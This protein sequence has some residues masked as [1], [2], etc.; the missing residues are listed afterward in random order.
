MVPIFPPL[1]LFSGPSTRRT[2]DSL[3][4]WTSLVPFQRTGS[5]AFVLP[6]SFCNKTSPRNTR[7]SSLLGKVTTAVL[8]LLIER[9]KGSGG[10]PRGRKKKKKKESLLD[11]E[12]IAQ[13]K[14][15]QECGLSAG[16][17]VV[18]SLS[19]CVPQGMTQE[20][21]E[22]TLGSRKRRR[23]FSVEWFGS[24]PA[25]TGSTHSHTHSA[26]IRVRNLVC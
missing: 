20:E 15:Y 6:L 8:P 3:A 18:Y 10:R 21:R 9:K 4:T 1:L 22:Q 12:I 25:Q 19:Q 13:A 7:L 5:S 24:K 26:G 16:K 2:N 14:S 11:P 17:M 23:G